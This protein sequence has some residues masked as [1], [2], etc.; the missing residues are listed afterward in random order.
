MIKSFTYTCKFCRHERTFEAE[1][2]EDPIIVNT[3][4]WLKNMCCNR[5]AKHHIERQKIA[6]NIAVTCD[7]LINARIKKGSK[8]FE[9]EKICRD[10]INQLCQKFADSVC[11]YYLKQTVIQDEFYEMIFDHPDNFNK[12]LNM[13]I[14]GISTI[15]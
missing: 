4:L 3:A 9:I 2:G 14:R 13:Y 5:C 1:V 12:F 15:K 11:G 6:K 7:L 8:L 10:K